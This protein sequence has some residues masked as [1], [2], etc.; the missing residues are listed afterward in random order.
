MLT[1]VLEQEGTGWIKSLG[2]YKERNNK[3]QCIDANYHK[4]IDNHGQRTVIGIGFNRK[5]G[6][7][8][9]IDKSYS[10]NA[11]DYRGLNR[12]QTQ[13]AVVKCGQ[14]VGRKINPETGKRDDYNPDIKTVQRVELRSDDKT[15][16]LTT[17]QKDD[18]VCKPDSYRK[19]TPR[20]CFRLQT[21]Q[22]HL[23]DK[24][25]SCGVSNTQ[26]YKIAGNG[27]TDEVIAHNLRH[28]R[29]CNA[30]T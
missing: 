18:L 9:E 21:V 6:L 30:N 27:W 10:L 20:E 22:E 5:E 23:I 25:L 1:D 8:K 11:S 26:L 17:V 12:N 28:S 19:L 16:C 4:G 2:E 15:S 14:M 3:S 29:L 24:I 7:I 13:T